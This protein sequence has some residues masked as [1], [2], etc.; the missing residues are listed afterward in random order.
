MA[1]TRNVVMLL[2]GEDENLRDEFLI[3]GAH[4]DHLGMGG[5]G[6]SSRAQLI[7]SACIMVQTIMLQEWH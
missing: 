3:F 1:I 7:Q 6:S 5:P 4:F 2:P